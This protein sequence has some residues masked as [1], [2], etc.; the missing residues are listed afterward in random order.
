MFKRW[1]RKKDPKDGRQEKREAIQAK[2]DA[3][4]SVIRKM[5]LMKIDRRVQDLPFTG[6][7]RRF[8]HS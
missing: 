5:D 3:A 8:S 1:F 6:Q 7:D 4:A 2:L